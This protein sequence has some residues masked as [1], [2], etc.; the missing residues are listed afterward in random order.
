LPTATSSEEPPRV[1]AIDDYPP[2]WIHAALALRRELLRTGA[3]TGRGRM[4]VNAADCL[5]AAGLA[6]VDPTDRRAV[7]V[8]PPDR[9]HD[10]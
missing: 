1:V 3:V 6:D 2:R 7:R 9:R 10:A 5:Y 8:L 4:F